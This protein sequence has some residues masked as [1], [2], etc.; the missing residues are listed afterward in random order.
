M[1]WPLSGNV[2]SHIRNVTFSR[3]GLLPLRLGRRLGAGSH[4]VY[5]DFIP[6]Y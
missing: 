1:D 5:G 6:G 4:F 3:L 2:D